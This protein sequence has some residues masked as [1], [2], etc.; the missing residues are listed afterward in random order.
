MHFPHPTAVELWKSA[1]PFDDRHPAGT[2]GN[3]TNRI[4]TW[5]ER[6]LSL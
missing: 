3:V 6:L 1:T 4:A 5:G 2:I